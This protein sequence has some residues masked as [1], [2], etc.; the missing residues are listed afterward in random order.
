MTSRSEG[1]R[2]L[3]KVAVLGLACGL[4]SAQ[5]GLSSGG[6]TTTREHSGVFSSAVEFYAGTLPEDLTPKV[7]TLVLVIDSAALVGCEDLGRAVRASV[8]MMRPTIPGDLHIWTPTEVDRAPATE[9][10]AGERLLPITLSPVELGDLRTVL[11]AEVKL[12]A[13]F[14]VQPSGEITGIGYR[15]KVPG[16]RLVPFDKVIRDF[17]WNL[18]PPSPRQR[19]EGL[20]EGP[21]M[22]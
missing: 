6:K 14:L 5:L 22:N 12:P 15:Y 16:A 8:R 2:G 20:R 17:G 4:L 18:S 7:P 10:A 9:Y 3:G 1:L 11:G 13:L 21:P 19:G